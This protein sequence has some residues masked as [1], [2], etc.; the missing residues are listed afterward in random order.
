MESLSFYQAFPSPYWGLIFYHKTASKR[1]KDA[2]IIGF[3]PRVVGRKQCV[4][5]FTR[6]TRCHNHKFCT[7]IRPRTGD[8][9][10]IWAWEKHEQ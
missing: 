4:A 1:Y 9:L 3:R 7:E 2:T 10:F 6:R 8:Y 5:L